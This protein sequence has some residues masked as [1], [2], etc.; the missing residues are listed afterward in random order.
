MKNHAYYIGV[1]VSKKTLDI[2]VLKRQKKLFHLRVSNDQKGLKALKQELKKHRVEPKETLLCLENT[3]FYGYNL[4]C[5]AVKNSYHVWLENAIAIKRSLGLV[6]GKNDQ[7]DSYRIALYAFRFEDKCTLWQPPRKSIRILQQLTVTRT[8]LMKSLVSL[9]VPLKENA[10][11]FPKDE[12]NIVERC[13]SNALKALEKSIKEVEKK[14]DQLIKEDTNLSRIKEIVTSVDGVGNQIATAL[15]V[16]TNE[17][18]DIR[19][20][21]KLACYAGVVPFEHTSG[22]SIRGKTRVSHLANKPLKSLLHMGAMSA[23]QNSCEMS[24]YYERK[25]AEG[26]PKMVVINAIRNKLI[27]RICV[28]VKQNRMYEKN[29]T[30]KLA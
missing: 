22:T 24:K 16:A 12:R 17:F 1:D 2:S 13:C 23:V 6:R 5:W 7:V 21:R 15:I 26:K 8:R 28:C 27:S 29:Y 20:E 4:S 18:K 11:I 3:G 25:V 30:R 19:N 9:K 10:L 14:I